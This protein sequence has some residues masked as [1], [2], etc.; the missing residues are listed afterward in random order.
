MNPLHFTIAFTLSILA[1]LPFDTVLAEPDAESWMT[2]RA[3]SH[4]RVNKSIDQARS[5][6]LRIF[7]SA[8]IDGGGISA[9]DHDLQRKVSFA[10]Q[11]SGKIVRWLRMDLD[12]DGQVTLSEL[13]LSLGKRARQPIR[14]QGVSLEPTAEQIAKT[15]DALLKVQLKGDLDGDQII[16]FKEMTAAANADIAKRSARFRRSRTHVP[17]SLDLNGDKTVSREEFTSVADRVLERFD[18]DGDGQFSAAEIADLRAAAN[19]FQRALRAAERTRR[20]EAKER[21]LAK[22]CGFP[23]AQSG[24]KLIVLSAARGRALSS[25]SLGDDSVSVSVA[26]AWIEP[27]TKPLY[28]VLTSARPMI[29]QFSGSV[30]RVQSLVVSAQQR[31]AGKSALA[32][33][34]GIDASRVHIPSRVDCLRYFRGSKSSQSLRAKARIK[35]LTGHLPDMLLSTSSVSTV[36]LPGGVFDRAAA[37]ENSVAAPVNSAGASLWRRFQRSYPG[38][39]VTIDPSK[40]VADAN[41][42]PYGVL[43]EL[44]GLAG[45]VDDGS[46][47]IIATQDVI[48]VG[49]TEIVTGGGADRVILQGGRKAKVGKQPSE[50]LIVKK[51]QFPAGLSGALSAKFQLAPGVPEPTGKMGH[52]CV[53]YQDTGKPLPG[54]RGCR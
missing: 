13:K 19:Q 42:K 31:R 26:N 9:T 1:F 27:G 6:L 20:R 3:K 47:K 54:S 14:S 4:A 29:W 24:T 28:V 21:E 33:V 53:R 35:A 11:R 34:V 32:G 5:G 41:V 50:F 52:S 37:Y 18:S 15:L 23:T 44:A 36:S 10:Q 12:G 30:D 22:S 45:L 8:D 43:P 16:T 49:Q 17:M 38:G 2:V 7:Q 51:I 39:L 25:V 48:R 46:L 40:V